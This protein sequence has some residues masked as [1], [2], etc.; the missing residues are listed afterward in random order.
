MKK[1]IG[2]ITM[3]ILI[4]VISIGTGYWICWNDYNSAPLVIEQ[5][6][7]VY[8]TVYRDYNSLKPNECKDELQEY[9]LGKPTLDIKIIGQRKIKATAGLYKR[10]WSREAK[11][12][13]GSSG[14]WKLYVGIGTGILVGGGLIYGIT[15]FK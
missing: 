8:K 5:E 9:D 2:I 7:I 14:N 11:I 13:V 4:I 12:K 15:R 6:K 10:T 1:T 3:T